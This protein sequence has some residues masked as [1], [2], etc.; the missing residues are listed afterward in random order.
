[1]STENSRLYA[2]AKV[3]SRVFHLVEEDLVE[4][5][6]NRRPSHLLVMTVDRKY[7]KITNSLQTILR[8]MKG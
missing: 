5:L 2:L 8:V 6:R 4:E 7:R 3:I 1:M